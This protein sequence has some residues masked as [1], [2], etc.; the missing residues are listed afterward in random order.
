MT[1]F[2]TK[3]FFPI[4]VFLVAF[5]LVPWQH[6]DGFNRI[7][8]DIGDARLNNY[9]LENIYLFLSGASSSLWHPSFYYPFPWVLGFSDNLFGSSPAYILARF[10]GAPADTA[11]QIWFMFGYVVN[12]GAAYWAL[13]HLGG[14]EIA[15]SVGALI[16]A[17]ALPSMAHMGHA[18]LHYR[19]GIPLALLFFVEFLALHRWKAL[20]VSFAWLV[21]QFY[22]GVYM[23][24]FALLMMMLAMIVHFV[25]ARVAPVPIAFRTE[26]GKFFESWNTL[27]SPHKNGLIFGFAVLVGALLLL[28]WPYLQVTKLYG[29]SRSWSDIRTMLPRPQSYIL[30]DQHFIWSVWGDGAFPELPMRHEH[31]MFVGMVPLL[32]AIAGL[33]I[34][35]RHS[36]PRVIWLLVGSM[37]A[38]I[39]VTLNIGGFS[40]WYLFHGLPLASAIRAMT[41]FDQVILFPI[42]VLAM[43]AIDYLRQR[44][45]IRPTFAISCALI[46]LCIAEM[47]NYN[48]GTSA[49]SEWRDRSVAVEAFFL[50]KFP[51]GVSPEAVIFI[52]QRDGPFYADELDAMWLGLRRGVAT[53]NGYTGNLPPGASWS[54][55]SD[56]YEIAKR[57]VGYQRLFPSETSDQDY[58]TMAA[59]VVPVGFDTCNQ[60]IFDAPITVTPLA[61]EYSPE[62]V[63]DLTYT[64][65]WFQTDSRAV[66]TLKN[67]GQH[68]FAAG[69]SPEGRALRLSW[70]FLDTSGQPL[71]GWENRKDLPYDILPGNSVDISVPLIVPT[72]ARELEV[73]MVQEG[74][75]W[76]HDSFVGIEP[77]KAYGN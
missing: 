36:V 26:L 13:R 17:F 73:S 11:F 54:F 66:V 25:M 67:A 38:I 5:F 47:M 60:E 53:M 37:G 10:F 76:F 1:K 27:S 39:L 65:T 23:G 31:Q 4:F 30:S 42:A 12:F 44:V 41:R 46:S 8:G 57:I 29:G 74:V 32:L 2:A 75:F 45:G 34:A 35:V 19:A 21:W 50:D 52:A 72:G 3:L 24:F 43:I 59:A 15:A 55:G 9:F 6:F 18:Q 58:K 49:K 61:T 22:A 16:F 64:V 68:M 7:P 20:L 69:V 63:R 77:A 51:E 28:F 48:P 33:I 40:L 70:R 14:T 62:E 71:S 56:C